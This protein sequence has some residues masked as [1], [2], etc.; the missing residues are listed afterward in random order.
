VTD[1]TS[2]PPPERTFNDRTIDPPGLVQDSTD[3]VSNSGNCAVC[4]TNLS[5]EGD[6]LS[7]DTLWRASMMA[8][9]AKD[10]YWHA[11][12][13][14]ET[15]E[16]PELTE[17]IADKCAS[18]HMPL[19]R[20][21]AVTNEETPYIVGDGYLNPENPLHDLAL[22][23]ISCTSCHQ[24]L[25]DNFGEKDSFSGHYLIDAEKRG[26]GERASFGPLPI[27]EGNAQIM[28]SAS[29]YQSIQSDHITESDLCGTCHN[30]YT[31]YLDS[32]G[33]IA[34]EFPE[35]TIHLEW[36]S[37]SFV[38]GSCADCHM[39]LVTEVPISNLVAEP[40]AYLRKHTFAGANAF[41]L[42]LLQANAAETGIT[43]EDEH[44]QAAVDRI[45]AQFDTNSGS[46]IAVSSAAVTDG[47][48]TADVTVA[49][50]NGH[51][52]PAGFPSRRIWVHFQV[53]DGSG[54]V[55]FDSGAVDE[56]GFILENDNDIDAA[57]YEPHYQ[58]IESPE[59][60]QIYEAIMHNTEDEVTTTLLRAARYLKD[61]R[62]LPAGFP[63]D[64]PPADIAPHGAVTSDDNFAGGSDSVRYVV[65][66][67]QHS[68]PFTL[69][70]DLLYQTIGYRWAENLREY[71]TLESDQF[72]F[73]YDQSDRT[74][75]VLGSDETV[76][77]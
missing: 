65:D 24:V 6:D 47:V 72:F 66:V 61:N 74:P 51:K 44:M 7:F 41:M 71:G 34:G 15:R 76:V 10:P 21:D 68:G 27:E 17:V 70:I 55:I 3:L 36:V 42:K 63:L 35:Q 23:G 19:A 33:E 73:Y 53:L 11:T 9:S 13:S 12:V 5:K 29:G 38:D 14:T 67:S 16:F 8:H 40:Q 58:V 54:E 4:H 52:R 1:E 57:L 20:F 48:L 49:N 75:I 37:S 25:P 26:F 62:L 56:L 50:N 39:P 59:Q 2:P 32:A 18:C 45:N 28:Q 46:E 31:P 64:D 60:V 43:A 77:E 69:S 22:D 30:L